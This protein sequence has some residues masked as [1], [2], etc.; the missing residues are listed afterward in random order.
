[1][2]QNVL[3]FSDVSGRDP[4]NPSDLSPRVRFLLKVRLQVKR[5]FYPNEVGQAGRRI[6]GSYQLSES[7][8]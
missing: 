5:E 3:R 2:R 6:V 1:M 4:G 8:F 7:F